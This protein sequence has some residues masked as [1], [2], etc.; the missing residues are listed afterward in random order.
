MV[1][2]KDY[3]PE[4]ASKAGTELMHGWKGCLDGI[5]GDQEFI[6]KLFKL[7]RSFSMI[8]Q[9]LLVDRGHLYFQSI[10]RSS[11]KNHENKSYGLRFLA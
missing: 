8:N 1:Q 9:I 2:D 5:Q 3:Q 4:W 11:H 7:K 10:L 6:H